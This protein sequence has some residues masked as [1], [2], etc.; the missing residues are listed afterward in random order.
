DVTGDAFPAGGEQPFVTTVAAGPGG[1]IAAGGRYTAPSGE[2]RE[3]YRGQ[4][5]QPA[6]DT[7]A[8]VDSAQLSAGRVMDAVPITNGF[9]AV[10][11][12]D[13]GVAEGRETLG[14]PEPDGVVWVTENGT[15]WAR[16]GTQSALVDEASLAFLDDPS[17][18]TAAVIAQMEAEAPPESAPPA[19]GDGTRSLSAVAPL[20]DGFLAVGSAYVD[21]DADPVIVA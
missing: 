16:I 10:G 14:D 21:G 13:F 2:A 15:D 3:S 9:V 8:E 4:V 17:P 11:F 19:G 7:W 12:E 18:E 20:G 6:G 5:W 1:T